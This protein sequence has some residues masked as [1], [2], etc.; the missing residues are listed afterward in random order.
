VTFR[1]TVP[2]NTVKLKVFVAYPDGSTP[3]RNAPSIVRP[4]C[5]PNCVTS[6]TPSTAGEYSVLVQ[7]F[8]STDT[9]KDPIA[10]GK[11]SF[12][13]SQSASSST[14]HCCVVQDVQNRLNFD[15]KPEVKDA[16]ACRALNGR[17]W[18]NSCTSIDNAVC[19]S[20]CK[21]DQGT[22]GGNCD[23]SS[24]DSYEGVCLTG[25]CR[26][27]GTGRADSR[28]VPCK[29]QACLTDSRY[30]IYT[31]PAVTSQRV[32]VPFGT[33]TDNPQAFILTWSTTTRTTATAG[34]YVQQPYALPGPAGS[35]QCEQDEF[36]VCTFVD[37]SAFTANT[38]PPVS[39]L[40]GTQRT[41]RFTL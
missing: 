3:E 16:P 11:R 5:P 26:C 22:N 14:G 18:E 34:Q 7:A 20:F 10:Y 19:D 4:L 38:Q 40:P 37:F 36:C 12:S 6:F 17:W 24:Q 1:L 35:Y 31:S 9:D 27:Q 32:Q 13:V 8:D 41:P 2:E 23:Q 29:T 39:S 33:C 30:S 25:Y 15:Y 21:N 28:N